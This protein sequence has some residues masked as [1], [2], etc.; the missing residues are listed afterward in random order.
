MNP[1]VEANKLLEELGITNFPIHASDVIDALNISR[2]EHPFDSIDGCFIFDPSGKSTFIGIN[3][4]IKERG[5]KNFTY[6]HELG[7][8][9][10]HALSGISNSCQKN[11]INNTSNKL[12]QIEMDANIFASH[13]LL[14]RFLI[15]Q[16]IRNIDQIDPDWNLISKWANSTETSLITMAFRYIELTEHKCL[17]AIVNHNR[18]IKYFKKS[19]NWSLYLD[20]D[21]RFLSSQSYAYEAC[22]KQ[23]IP[24]GF[25][26]VPASAWVSDRRIFDNADI[27]EWSLPL[28]S[29]GDILT[30]L[31]DDEDLLE[32]H[33]SDVSIFYKKYY[34]NKIAGMWDPPTFHKSKRKP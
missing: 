31:W 10:L 2:K 30:L 7:H 15:R 1:E 3:S 34:N 17:L 29:Y 23:N 28:N 19:R 11:D 27:L 21:S 14:P 16:N 32:K 22:N 13:L 12:H 24:D 20:M 5:R 33:K 6:A 18:V 26:C 8:Y 9:C 25:E 4:K